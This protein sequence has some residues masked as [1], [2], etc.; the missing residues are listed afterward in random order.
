MLAGFFLKKV[1]FTFSESGLF[2]FA[3]LLVR[4]LI[5]GFG[6]NF[7]F[8]TLTNGNFGYFNRKFKTHQFDPCRLDDLASGMTHS[9]QAEHAKLTSHSASSNMYNMRTWLTNLHTAGRGVWT[10]SAGASR[11]DRY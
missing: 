4:I 6:T 1:V 9:A 7:G 3:T 5:S 8:C 10:R 11:G 2:V